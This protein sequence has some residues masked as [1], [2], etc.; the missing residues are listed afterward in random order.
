LERTNLVTEVDKLRFGTV[1]SPQTTPTSGTPA[2]IAHIRQLGLDHLEIAWVQS[3]RVSDESCA[4]IKA[5]AQKYGVTLSIH[6]PYYINLNSQ[7]PEL[8]AKSDERLLAAAR[9]GYLAG[10]R[11][12]I[13]HP[14]S[15]HSQ[16]PEQVYER[17][18]QKLLELTGI[19]RQEGVAVNL[20]PET[21]GKS[22]MFGSLDEVIQLSKEV[23]GVRPCIDWAHL[24]ARRGDGTFNSYD[25]FADALVQVK[26]GLGEAGLKT[27]HFHISGIA[28][29]PKGE[30]SHIPL[31]EADLRYREL[32]QAFIDFGVEGTAAIEAPEPFHTADALTFQATYR[33][34]IALAAGEDESADG[35]E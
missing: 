10:A 16:P 24:H 5:M 17:A 13:F 25:E 4:E 21:M 23:P 28:Y 14:G 15:Y 12:I 20:R 35:E 18:K 9:K 3:V 22:A 1:G 6:A 26:A 31:N 30:K 2:A 29:T 11:D 33:R 8:M 34:L 19:L 32:L 27:M 7:T